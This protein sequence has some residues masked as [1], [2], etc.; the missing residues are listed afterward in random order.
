[1]RRTMDDPSALGEIVSRLP[2]RGSGIW[3]IAL[4]I[5]FGPLWTSESA[6]EQAA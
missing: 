6:P 2:R 3:L 5:L 1:M 4:P